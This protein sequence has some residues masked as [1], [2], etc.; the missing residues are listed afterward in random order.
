MLAKPVKDKLASFENIYSLCSW[1]TGSWKTSDSIKYALV[2]RG[3]SKEKD[4]NKKK[5]NKSK[6]QGKSKCPCKFKVT[7]WNCGK[8]GHIKK[9]CKEKKRAIKN[10]MIF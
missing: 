4:K 2:I 8:K 9:D 10:Q 3:R 6:S 1:S 5:G 7:C